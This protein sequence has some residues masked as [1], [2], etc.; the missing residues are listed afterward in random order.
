MLKVRCVVLDLDDT[1]YLE[2]DYV[3][4]GFRACSRIFDDPVVRT[5]FFEQAWSAFQTGRRGDIF[6]YT[7]GL[8]SQP[9]GLVPELVAAYRQHTPCIQ[10]L[11]DARNFLLR[12]HRRVPLAVITD[13]PTASQRNKAVTLG[14]PQWCEPI[15]LTAEFGQGYSKPHPRAF[16]QVERVFRCRGSDCVYIA[17]NPAKDF[18]APHRLGWQTV[19]LR[20]AQGL[21]ADVPSGADVDR[22]VQNLSG[23]EFTTNGSEGF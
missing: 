17:D 3:R 20:R 6:D 12:L 18:E 1:L 7:L 13:G 15:I 11:D 14:L 16:E 8:L 21:H 23:L 10:L 22:E 19:R 2:R 9:L 5:A 4:S